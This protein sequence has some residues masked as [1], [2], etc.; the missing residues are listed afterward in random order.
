MIVVSSLEQTINPSY[1]TIVHATLE[2][3]LVT[4]HSYST[5]LATFK[6]LIDLQ[7]IRII[8]ERI[9]KATQGSF[10]IMAYLEPFIRFKV[11]IITVIMVAI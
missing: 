4:T 5:N 8:Q 1:F 3:I 6:E 10:I 2:L 9:I 7:S 11:A